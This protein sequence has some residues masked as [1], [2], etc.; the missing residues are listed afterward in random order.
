MSQPV[1][2]NRLREL[3]LQNQAMGKDLPAERDKKVFVD[4]H[5]RIVLN[6]R[7]GEEQVLSEV[8]QGVFA[9][10]R[11]RLARDKEVAARKLPPNT[12]F[13]VVDGVPGWRY[14]IHDEFGQEY[15]MFLYFDGSLY[16]VKVVYPEVEGRY[17]P[18]HGHLFPDGRICFGEQGGLPTLEQAYAK[19]V[20]WANG[21]TVFRMTGKFPFSL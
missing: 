21:F 17:S 19:S 16:Q 14:T 13:L 1:D 8:H 5:G 18:H 20:L 2:L 6:P 9:G 4:R 10:L 3:V 11:E 15:V 12:E 7:T